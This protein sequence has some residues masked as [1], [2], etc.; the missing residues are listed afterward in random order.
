MKVV[1]LLRNRLHKRHASGGAQGDADDASENSFGIDSLSSSV[2]NTNTSICSSLKDM[3]SLS[4]SSIGKNRNNGSSSNTT[5]GISLSSLT[6][7]SVSPVWTKT[8]VHSI[9][10]KFNDDDIERGRSFCAI[11]LDE[12]Q[13]DCKYKSASTLM[14]V[15]MFSQQ[16]WNDLNCSK[17]LSISNGNLGLEDI[18]EEPLQLEVRGVF[19]KK[20]HQDRKYLQLYICGKDE[21][22]RRIRI[23]KRKIDSK[24]KHDSRSVEP[25]TVSAQQLDD[26]LKLKEKGTGSTLP[27]VHHHSI[28]RRN[29]SDHGIR[30]QRTSVDYET[31]SMSF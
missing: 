3:A 13:Q 11:D 10:S 1:P 4:L 26:E 7:L 20:T 21:P 24:A 28:Q 22:R 9:Y 30:R 27:R 15:D 23:R 5:L 31:F 25:A 12:G 29:N 19:T 6:N 17:D 14:T 16:S 2:A 18:E 8:S